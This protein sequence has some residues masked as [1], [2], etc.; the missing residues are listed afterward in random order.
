M[1]ELPEALD[2]L[3]KLKYR[4]EKKMADDKLYITLSKYLGGLLLLLASVLLVYED[5]S[6]SISI[7]VLQVMGLAILG[8]SLLWDYDNN[9]R[10]KRYDC[11]IREIERD[12]SEGFNADP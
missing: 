1:Q 3:E 2:E 8:G 5:L 9:S 12:E 10:L 6:F 11:K 4:L 7:I